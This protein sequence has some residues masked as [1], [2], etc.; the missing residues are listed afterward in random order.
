MFYNEN[1]KFTWE[2]FYNG[3]I[4]VCVCGYQEASSFCK[5]LIEQGVV[6]TFCDGDS[7][8]DELCTS[9]HFML[10]PVDPFTYSVEY[11]GLCYSPVNRE[12]L[13]FVS[14]NQFLIDTCSG[15]YI[16]VTKEKDSV[17]GKV[18]GFEF[19]NRVFVD[20]IDSIT[21]KSPIYIKPK[22]S[23][24]KSAGYD[25]CSPVD[26]RLAPGEDIVIKLGI[27]AYMQDDEFLMIAPRSGLGFKFYSRLAN[28]VGIIDADYYNNEDNE[29]EIAVKIRNESSDK[30]L[31]VEQGKAI[32]QAIFMKYL[33]VDGDSTDEG[34][35]RTGG[36][37]STDN[38]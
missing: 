34:G 37:G 12:E 36:F 1:L 7:I 27:K 38:K 8:S 23:T 24:K 32:C 33:L 6:I 13:P 21:G 14:Y 18:R 4:A 5:K 3:E 31:I 19:V 15:E 2:K 25:I 16:N 30:E 35:E 22:R 11:K 17:I 10:S 9:E 29:G 28:T 26:F 20:G